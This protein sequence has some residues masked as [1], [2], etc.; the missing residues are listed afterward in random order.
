MFLLLP[1]NHNPF[2]VVCLEPLGVACRIKTEVRSE[3]STRQYFF[4]FQRYHKMVYNLKMY[5]R[6]K[7][8]MTSCSVFDTKY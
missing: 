4:S 3:F 7:Q 6:S 8:K 2:V 1:S 5:F